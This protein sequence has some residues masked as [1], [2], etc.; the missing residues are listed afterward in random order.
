[1]E[2]LIDDMLSYAR[3][4][5]AATELASV[6]LDAMVRGILE[7]QPAPDGFG[8]ALDLAVEP[9]PATRT[10]LETALRN[11]IGN[12]FRHHDRPTG[13]VRIA[14]RAA[15]QFCEISVCDDGPGVPEASRARLFKLF[16][17]L[18]S[19]ERAGSG[20][21]LALTKRLV[22]VHGGRIAV[23]SP[24]EGGRGACFRIWWPRFPRRTNDE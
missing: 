11:L 4:G 19:S 20:I 22:E 8:V 15:D 17:T 21:G 18:T 6:D 13:S 3:A 23:E 2:R 14:A 7:I 9:F 24:V 12:A 16:Q 1:M 5:R 10:P